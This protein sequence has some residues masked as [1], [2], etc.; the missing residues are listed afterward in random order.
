MC[1]RKIANVC[2]SIIATIGL[3]YYITMSFNATLIN[4]IVCIPVL[5]LYY[6]MYN[7]IEKDKRTIAFSSIISIVYSI[8]LIIGSQLELTSDIQWGIKTTLKIGLLAFSLFPLFYKLIVFI[9]KKELTIREVKIKSERKIFWCVYGIL[10]FFGILG[11]LALY[12]GQFGYDAGFQIMQVQFDD[13]SITTHFSVIYSYILY[14]FVEI[15]NKVFNNYDIGLALYAFF[16]MCV[17]TYVTSKICIFTYR[18]SKNKYFLLGG[19]TFFAIFP[20][21]IIMMLSTAQDTIY[22]GILALI[23]MESYD[24]IKNT[25]E[26][27]KKVFKPIKFILLVALLCMF[28]NSG[29]Y[30]IMFSLIFAVA[31]AKKYRIKVIAM[32]VIAISI[33]FVYKGPL[34]SALKVVD[35][36]PIR[37]MSSIPCQQIARTYT[38][39]R[40]AFSETDKEL[41]LKV[42]PVPENE[43]FQYYELRSSISDIVKGTLDE[44]YA[45]D[46]IKPISE[47]YVVTGTKDP[48]NYAE[49][50]LLNS[51]GFWYPNKNY[52]DSR[53]YHPYIE[54][55]MLDSKLYN[56]RYLE[57]SRKS[58]FPLYTKVLEKVITKNGWTKLPV[59]SVLFPCGTYFLL[60]LFTIVCVLY[61][62]DYRLLC[63]LSVVIGYFGTLL[64]S[65]VCI[66]RYCY[67]LILCAPILIAFCLKKN[68]E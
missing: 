31:F 61:K 67:A 45:K 60:L 2:L 47:M 56:Q 15:G 48:E 42:F 25:E 51:L 46:N 23:V 40:A 39:N 4:N 13:V 55:E 68:N 63:P 58:L 9:M 59:V 66:F 1:V 26:Y 16:Q 20:L 12:P 49:G 53:I 38:Y 35:G 10:L 54:S 29:L 21:H 50:F 8:I 7:K 52:P 18:L 57:F 22:C 5:V 64:L 28:K 3:M 33:F 44:K 32:Y 14:G 17:L 24:L 19:I 6:N 62:K 43:L 30:I 36:D 27:F 37:E 41:L 34:F 11:F 65:P